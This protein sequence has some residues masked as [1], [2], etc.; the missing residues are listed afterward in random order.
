MDIHHLRIFASVYKNLSFTLASRELNI[1]QPTISEHIKNLEATLD[2]RLFDRLGRSILPTGEAETIYPKVLQ[3]LDDFAALEEELSAAAGRMKGEVVL[4]ASTIPGTYILPALAAAFKKKY[5]EMSFTILID[6]SRR[7][8]EKVLAHELLLGV[9]GARDKAA[10]LSYRPLAADELI[11]A[12]GPG[13]VARQE[14]SLG[15]LKKLPFLLREQG[16]GTRKCMEEFLVSSGLAVGQLNTV[17]TLGSTASVKEAMR[18]GLGVSILSLLAVREELK[19]GKLVR[20]E[21]RGLVMRRSFYLVTSTLRT[22]PHQYR[23]FVDHLL[24]SAGTHTL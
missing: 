23:A 13:M 12:A 11:L 22:L 2:C 21:V 4:G 14:I 19:T 5:P 18:A 24:E 16:S 3:L 6:D 20:I 9:V 7:V 8:T 1:S 15:E 10:R 17:A